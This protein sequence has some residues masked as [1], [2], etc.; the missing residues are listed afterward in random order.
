MP[1]KERGGLFLGV[2]VGSVSAN[3]V[4]INSQKT[5]IEEH[6][7]RL[8]GQPIATVRR[9]LDDI[10]S[11]IPPTDF[12]DISFVGTGGKLL[13]R[14]LNANFVNEIIAQGKAIEWL[15]PNV[16]TVIEMGGE[17]SKLILL[18]YDTSQKK[19]KLMD[20]SMNTMCAAGTGSFLDQQANEPYH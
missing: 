9:I 12:A 15:H 8:H 10:F 13:A 18:D 17:D 7:H 11:R 4:I 2:D 5:I 14:L 16:R 19:A 3:T 1:Q 6:Y 20:F